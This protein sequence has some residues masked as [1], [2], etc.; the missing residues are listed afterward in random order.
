[1]TRTEQPTAVSSSA[2]AL[3]ADSRERAVRAL[4]HYPPLRRLWSAQFVSGIGDALAVLALLALSFQAAVAAGAFGGGY[5]GAALAIAAVFGARLLATLLFGAV[6]LGPLAS[7]IGPSGPLDRRWT[8]IGADGVR[9]VL[10]VIAPLWIDWMPSDAVASLLVTAFVVGVAERLWTVAKDGAAP[11]L[12]PPPPLEGAAVRPL[13][14]HLDALRRLSLRTTAVSLPIA[15]AGMLVVTL[16]GNV[17]G[18]GVDWFHQHQPALASYVAAGL[19]AASVSVL[20]FLELP[21]AQ[22]TRARS[23]LEGLRR[24][25]VPVRGAGGARDTAPDKGRTGAI[26]VLVPACAAVAGAM[27][28]AFGV[29][30]LQAADLGGGPVG[31]SLLALMIAGGPVIGVRCAPRVLPA[32]SRRRLFALAITATGLALLATGLV[33][34]PATVLLLALLAGVAAGIAAN[35]GHTLLDQETEESRRPRTTE[36]LHAVVRVALALG[37]LAAPLLAAAIGPHRLENGDFVFAHGGA[38]FTL[39]LVGAL[40][41][42]VA[43]LVLGK[44]DDRQGVPLRRDLRDA[45]RG[46]EPAEAPAANGFFIAFE[47]GDGA[48]KSTQVTAIAEWIRSKGHEVVV[49]REPG[50]TAIGKRLRSILLDVASAG[51]SHRA[52]ALLYAADRAEHVDSVVRPA[53]ERGAVVISDRYIDSSVAYQGAGR[54]L[55]PTEIARISRWATDGLVPHLTVLLDVSP[56]AARERFTEAP[57]RLESEPA[58]FHQRV[59]AGFLTL[60][61]AAP[62]RYLVVDAS[63]EPEAVSTVVRHRLD[64][65]LPLSQAEIEA[66]EEARR[67]AEEEARRRAEEEAARKAEEER[68]ER[69]RQ[70]QLARLRA[71]EEERKRREAEE[72][73][74]LEAE[75][76]AEEARQRAEE[77][78]RLAEQERQRREAEERARA[79]EEERQRRQAEEEARLRAEAEARRLEKQ[80]KAEEALLRAEQAR[81]AAEAAAALPEPGLGGAP[82]ATD[83]APPKPGP[84]SARDEAPTVPTPLV[85][86]SDEGRGGPAGTA[87]AGTAE[88]GAGAGPA[89]GPPAAKP[90]ATAGPDA[91]ETVETPRIDPR[92]PR[93]DA[94][95]GGGAGGGARSG[96]S[97]DDATRVLPRVR[98]EADSPAQGTPSAPGA[99]DAGAARGVRGADGARDPREA[100]GAHDAAGTPEAWD[101][102]E[103]AQLP[104]PPQPETSTGAMDE[105]A[106]LPAVGAEGARPEAERPADPADRVPPWMFRPESDGADGARQAAPESGNERTR[107]LPQFDPTQAGPGPGAGQAPSGQ[108]GA[109]QADEPGADLHGR[110]R[111]RP[112]WAEETPLDDLPTLADEL[113]GPHDAAGGGHYARPDER[114]PGGYDVPPSGHDV[115]P[116]GYDGRD[117]PPNEQP[118]PQDSGSRGSTGNGRPGNGRRGWGRKG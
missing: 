72:A 35:I 117:Q 71:E 14:D 83:T 59:R 49:T 50:A 88:A 89:A 24:P 54:D 36:H 13:P 30:L 60:A 23:P 20:F 27:A 12:L 66:R 53:L 58:E 84:P 10:L 103:T 51:L 7:L 28:A 109:G 45:V 34:D 5:R 1:M 90:R 92:A 41:L 114:H 74:R 55:S 100:A 15:A 25:K 76:Q 70:E 101:T 33:P 86:P 97:V 18:S 108:D 6:L 2:G 80:R 9:L 48:G 63:Q 8:M 79:A 21:G 4:L 111:R 43:A 112:E 64:Q 3:A 67:K 40:L 65:V 91:T 57:D 98:P 118:G 96:G 44:T 75:R 107:E 102:E 61:A 94:A 16:L 99:R 47:G 19:F 62:A 82:G 52:E 93:P 87:A 11:A 39:M 95:A 69:E 42:P 32:L 115:S 46:G 56:E 81:L 17:L 105:T 106:V 85:K 110:K 77:E 22:A 31:F 116:G 68:L 26:P 78:R 37:V 29:A 73:K 113:L 38:A 104:T